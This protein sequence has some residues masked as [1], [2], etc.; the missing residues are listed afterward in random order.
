MQ[1]TIEFLSGAFGVMCSAIAA[2]WLHSAKSYSRIM[3]DNQTC[4]ENFAQLRE[5]FGVL[6]GKQ[7][8]V[9]TLAESVL[10]E[11]RS[12]RN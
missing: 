3:K 5:E 7:Q 10:R 11:I 8:G 6:K 12:I 1:L 2:Q 4:A 9:E